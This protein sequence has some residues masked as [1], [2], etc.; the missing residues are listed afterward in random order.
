MSEFEA[1]IKKAQYEYRKMLR[2]LCPS[3][4]MRLQAKRIQNRYYS[5]D[6]CAY[7]DKKTFK[8]RNQH[9][10]MY[11]FFID[12]DP[13]YEG[14]LRYLVKEAEKEQEREIEAKNEMLSIIAETLET[15][16]DN[17][18]NSMKITRSFARWVIMMADGNW[19]MPLNIVKYVREILDDLNDIL[20]SSDED[21]EETDDEDYER[22]EF[23]DFDDL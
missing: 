7:L 8:C 5:C 11:N 10:N 23:E 17:V 14:I 21:D 9:E 15:A 1:E 12:V 6:K 2:Q 20:E 22:Y 3:Q 19:K 13:C 18:N 16:V 4:E